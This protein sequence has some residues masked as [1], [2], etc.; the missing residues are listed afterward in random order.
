MLKQYCPHCGNP[1][2]YAS[3]KPKFCGSCGESFGTVSNSSIVKKPLSTA[4]QTVFFQ[5]EVTQELPQID[6]LEIVVKGSRPNYRGVR[7][8]EIAV[9]S[10]IIE[11][12]G[13]VGPV[14]RKAKR[15]K[16]D[17]REFMADARS[18]GRN[19]PIEIGE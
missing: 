10:K 7:M 16:I 1:N 8:S 17:Q 9:G 3:E 12:T 19:N 15:P 11:D 13:R 2:S 5:N 18:S 14:N 6:K 4:R